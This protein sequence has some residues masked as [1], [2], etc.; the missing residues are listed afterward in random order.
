MSSKMD[1]FYPGPTG[2]SSVKA[3]RAIFFFFFGV[4]VVAFAIHKGGTIIKRSAG[5][6]WFKR[7]GTARKSCSGLT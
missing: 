4:V 1:Q 2:E 6:D 7:F 5:L 3:S